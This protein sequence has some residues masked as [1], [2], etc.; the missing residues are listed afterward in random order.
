MIAMNS[1][2]PKWVYD[3]KIATHSAMLR[4]AQPRLK[5]TTFSYTF[6][7]CELLFARAAFAITKG[8]MA[9]RASLTFGSSR[10]KSPSTTMFCSWYSIFSWSVVVE[11]C[12]NAIENLRACTSNTKLGTD[13]TTFV[14]PNQPV[15]I[16]ASRNLSCGSTAA[17]T[18]R[19]VV[20]AR[21]FSC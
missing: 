15:A 8:S 6:S 13:G 14:C 3:F 21:A 9:A 18:K 1:Y 5:K 4:S 17:L 10:I 19:E 12:W 2:Q 7:D 16:Q 20:T 11:F